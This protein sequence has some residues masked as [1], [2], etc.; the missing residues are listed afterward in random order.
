MLRGTTKPGTTSQRAGSRIDAGS[1][2]MIVAMIRPCAGWFAWQVTG[3]MG[4]SLPL[5]AFFRMNTISGAP[6]AF[7]CV[8]PRESGH[9]D[10]R[11]RPRPTTGLN[12]ISQLQG[13]VGVHD[14]SYRGVGVGG[15]DD[16]GY[17]FLW[18][19]VFGVGTFY[20]VLQ[21]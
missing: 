1:A 11:H 21:Y 16:Y 18:G 6:V 14:C 17:P 5:V 10:P 4:N 9:P 15:G 7:P 13:T 12:P 2:I 8:P 19:G 20:D 3:T